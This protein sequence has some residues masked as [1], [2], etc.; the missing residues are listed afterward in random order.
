MGFNWAPPSV[1]V[2]TI[3]LGATVEMIEQAGLPVPASLEAARD[4]R[5][6]ALLR[7]PQ[8][9]TGQVLRR[10]LSRGVERRPG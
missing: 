5:A 8:V 4:G 9:N 6:E 1:L 10:R 2:D 7:R 3:G